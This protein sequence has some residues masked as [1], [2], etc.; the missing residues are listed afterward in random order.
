[1]QPHKRAGKE[2]APA[3]VVIRQLPGL[4]RHRH[5]VPRLA[6]ER[7]AVAVDQRIHV[8]PQPDALRMFRHRNGLLMQR[9]RRY[10]VVELDHLDGS[11]LPLLVVHK[12]VAPVFAVV[13]AGQPRAL[14][15]VNRR[16]LHPRLRPE[17]EVLPAARHGRLCKGRVERVVAVQP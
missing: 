2:A 3:D 9:P 4:I 17:G 5:G 13:V 1:M 7:V 14:L 16:E 15:E 10:V 6:V 8:H 12:A 11:P